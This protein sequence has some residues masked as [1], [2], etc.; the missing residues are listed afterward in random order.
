MFFLSL[1]LCTNQM[2]INSEK[3]NFHC[4]LLYVYA[5]SFLY[6]KRANGDLVNQ[7]IQIQKIQKSKKF[8]QRTPWNAL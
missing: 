2:I 8:F 7:I 6:K 4:W 1:Y 5:L 3:K